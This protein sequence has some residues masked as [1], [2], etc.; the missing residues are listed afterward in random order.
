MKMNNNINLTNPNKF[1]A[2]LHTLFY[3][4][5]VVSVDENNN[6]IKVIEKKRS[7]AL[8]ITVLV[9]LIFLSCFYFI[10]FPD[11]VS[12]DQFGVIFKQMFVP[13][14]LS[15][16]TWPRYWSYLF[17]TGFP[18]IV[19][20]LEMVFIG[21]TFG[22]L[23]AF[24]LFILASRNVTKH[25]Y[26]YTPIRVLMDILRSIPTYV[27]ALISVAFFG[28][29]VTAG[30]IAIVIFTMGIMFKLMYEYIDTLDMNSFEASL[31]CGATRFQAFKISLLPATFPMLIS[32][33][34]YTFEINVRASVILAWA[35][36]GGIGSLLKTA[37]EARQY[38]KVGALLIPLFIVVFI[39]QVI[40]SFL[41]RKV[42]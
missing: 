38:D 6:P 29:G 30:I 28:I 31:S 1:K 42:L 39:L 19:Q 26:I 10:K 22:T 37:M 18:A 36:A 13:N 9:L 12:L 23:L 14:P 11:R 25:S 41:R 40:S 17:K 15:L 27:L 4:K 3:K 34:I 5:V 7:K 33:F 21:T 2:F 35:N 16:K 24:P 8:L 20:T 32:N